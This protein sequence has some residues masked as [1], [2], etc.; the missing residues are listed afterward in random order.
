MSTETF[1]FNQLKRLNLLPK[2]QARA[3][4]VGLAL[5]MSE[6]FERAS[7]SIEFDGDVSAWD[8]PTQPVLAVGDHSQGLESLL[9]I[10]AS[11]VAGRGDIGVTAKPYA[12]T[13]QV[14][15]ALT[16]DDRHLLGFIPGNMS[17][18]RRG[19]D[20]GVR[21]HRA[22]FKSHLPAN[23]HEARA[24]NNSSMERAANLIEEGGLV[25]IFPTG[26]VYDAATTPWKNGVGQIAASLTPDAFDET[27]VSQFR[28]D[29]VSPRRILQAI[30]KSR[31]GL[32]PKPQTIIMSL[33][34][35]GTLGDIFK[36]SL[37]P[38]AT[39]ITTVLQERYMSEF[40]S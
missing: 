30:V 18:D 25:T 27:V 9:V 8:S 37:A 13:G 5:A 14:V 3:G 10:G 15:N 21:A 23:R 12:L 36:D 19:G 1:E 17:T 2:V 31:T 28:F 4:E 26:G 40:D 20:F 35:Q 38:T 29:G 34:N 33:G 22:L 6:M 16:D 32:K 39:Q 24:Y 11:G 7:I